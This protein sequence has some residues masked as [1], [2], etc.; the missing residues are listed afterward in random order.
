[1]LP[2][3]PTIRCQAEVI[4]VGATTPHMQ[5]VSIAG[6]ALRQLTIDSPAQWVKLFFP[7][8][9]GVAKAGRAYT[10][11]R[12]DPAHAVMDIEF[13]LHGDHGPA[14]RWAA[15]A[16][17]GEIVEV[18][19]PR[20][21]HCINTDARNYILIGDA[22]AL[23]AIASILEHL[24][25]G[26]RAQAF[27]EVVDEAEHQPFATKAA[28]DTVWLHAGCEVPGTTG[29]LELEIQ[30]ADLAAQDCQVW[31]AG[32]SFMVRWVR[33]HLA[34]DRGIPERAIDAKAY[35]KVGVADARG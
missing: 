19:G 11:R 4:D 13:A 2:K 20:R 30:A 6:G 35:W 10:V 24:P 26:M 18:A 3:T 31:L 29:R 28:L 32:E 5:R 33:T 17:P 23:P 8:A 34:V 27:V 12:W 9:P 15:G 1:M 7:T 14:S 25:A 22:T 21:G 16:R